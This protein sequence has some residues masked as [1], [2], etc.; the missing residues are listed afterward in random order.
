M[1]SY[2]FCVYNFIDDLYGVDRDNKDS[3]D[4]ENIKV[5]YK[6]DVV[7]YFVN[8]CKDVIVLIF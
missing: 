5:I 1:V 6:I 2:Y 7:T 3:R 8:V 4:I